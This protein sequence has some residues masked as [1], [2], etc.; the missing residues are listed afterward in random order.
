M[1]YVGFRDYFFR[2]INVSSFSNKLFLIKWHL[3]VVS[4]V[5]DRNA[6]DFRPHTILTYGN[7]PGYSS[8]RADLTGVDTSNNPLLSAFIPRESK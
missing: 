6:L 1:L 4:G 3:I 5:H 7:G 8:P 2:S